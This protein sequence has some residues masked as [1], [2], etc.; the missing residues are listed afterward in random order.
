MVL[1]VDEALLLLELGVMLPLP[2]S[3]VLRIQSSEHDRYSTTP[4]GEWFWP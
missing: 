4:S 3:Y 1:A 2:A